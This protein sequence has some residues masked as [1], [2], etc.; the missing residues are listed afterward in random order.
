MRFL[1]CLLFVVSGAVCLVV[2]A[3]ADAA[4]QAAVHLDAKVE[5]QMDY[6]LY[7]PKDYDQKKAWPLVLF[8]HGAGERGDDLNLV[9]M[10]G[11]PRLI[12][13][14]K[15]FPFIVVSPQCP[16]GRW[17]R[18]F[19]LTALLDDVIATH[20]VDQDRVY[21]TGLSMGG[22]GS[23]GLAAFSPDRF[24]AI[25]PICGG[26]EPRSTRNFKHVPVWAFHGAKDTAVPLE[27]TQAMID[28]LERQGA[29]PK[30]T[31]YP[32]AGHDSWTE[33]Y[34][35]PAFYEWLLAQKRVAEED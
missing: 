16:K 18:E 12:E 2:P 4:D 10:H 31:I 25:A 17:W 22:F 6:L 26:G 14:G 33:T 13:E 29:E 11:P 27:R 3:A 23:W 35:N 34:N 1:T 15:E 28:A 8:L 19:E 7:L 20:N 24:A 30:L 21:V 5:V 32:E 9:K